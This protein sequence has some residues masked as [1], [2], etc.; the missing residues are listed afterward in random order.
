MPFINKFGRTVSNNPT[1]QV[2]IKLTLII[3]TQF[4]YFWRICCNTLGFCSILTSC[5]TL[6][7]AIFHQGVWKMWVEW[8][9][10]DNHLGL[11]KAFTVLNHMTSLIKCLLLI[12]MFIFINATKVHSFLLQPKNLAFTPIGEYKMQGCS[13]R[14]GRRGGGRR[15]Q[16]SAIKK[17]VS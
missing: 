10:C 9:E 4:L 13:Q 5:D 14:R 1:F 16:T 11:T 2:Q 6:T 12:K 3:L 8:Y 7:R 15:W 17:V